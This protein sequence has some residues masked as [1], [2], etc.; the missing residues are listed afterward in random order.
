MNKTKI[1]AILIGTGLLGVGVVSAVDPPPVGGYPNLNTALGEDAMHSMNT[2]QGYA[3]TAV[4][5]HSL[6]TSVAGQYKAMKDLRQKKM[7]PKLLCL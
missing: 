4:G 3:N 5:W 7:R 2:T 1:A 6:Y